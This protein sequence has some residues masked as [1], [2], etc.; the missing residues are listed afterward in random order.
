MLMVF[1]SLLPNQGRDSVI[2][3]VQERV[4]S[5]FKINQQRANFQNQ[6]TLKLFPYKHSWQQKFYQSRYSRERETIGDNRQIN[7][8]S[9]SKILRQIYTYM[10]TYTVKTQKHGQICRYMERYRRDH[11][12]CLLRNLYVNQEVTVRTSQGTTGW[13]QIGKGE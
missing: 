6:F 9:D 7:R 11:L 13:F 10:H 8:Q 2:S 1:I 3:I 12:P 5:V 4:I